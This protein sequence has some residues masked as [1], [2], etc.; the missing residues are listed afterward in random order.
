M[1]TLPAQAATINAEFLIRETL[2]M[3]FAE[4]ASSRA[5][6]DEVL[7]RID[8]LRQGSQ[9]SWRADCAAALRD[10][11]DPQSP[12]FLSNVCIGHPTQEA[13]LPWIGIVLMAEAEDPAGSMLGDV[14]TRQYTTTGDLDSNPEGFRVIR[15]E[16]LST[17]YT[18]TVQIAVWT[19]VPE[20]SIV[21]QATAQYVMELHKDIL[22]RAG[23]YTITLTT[24]SLSPDP[25]LE[26][27]VAYVPIVT[28]VLTF[29]RRR[30]KTTDPVPNRL[31]QTFI[32]T[33][34]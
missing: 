21:L 24:S 32:Y 4:F 7:D 3:G 8:M 20:L 29:P 19:T 1:S 25:T 31:T 18:A 23:V 10:T 6:Q 34:S 17:D 27:R 13:T 30:T 22:G 5:Q 15:H 12:N 11:F 14:L 2:I 26:P 9:E 16:V 28:C 33:S